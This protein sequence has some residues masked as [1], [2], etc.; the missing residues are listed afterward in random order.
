MYYKVIYKE[1][2]LDSILRCSLF[3]K[4][5]PSPIRILRRLPR[6]LAPQSHRYRQNLKL[7]G[8]ALGFFVIGTLVG[9]LYGNQRDEF[10]IQTFQPQE[11][12]LSSNLPPSMSKGMPGG[13][14]S[15]RPPVRESNP[16]RPF[17]VVGSLDFSWVDRQGFY[18]SSL[19]HVALYKRMTRMAADRTNH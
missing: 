14:T 3:P 1:Y 8:C 19:L 16:K 6:S 5:F 7:F 2:L 17:R 13:N 9:T 12:M 18:I 4:R 15:W 11:E 10:T